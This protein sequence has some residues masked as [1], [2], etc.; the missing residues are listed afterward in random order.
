MVRC[1]FAGGLVLFPQI[2]LAGYSC[3]TWHVSHVSNV[4]MPAYGCP[5]GYCLNPDP[6]CDR[7]DC[8]AEEFSETGKCCVL[9]EGA[10]D[11]C[12]SCDGSG[13]DGEPDCAMVKFGGGL[14]CQVVS[15]GAGYINYPWIANKRCVGAKEGALGCYNQVDL[16]GDNV[17]NDNGGVRLGAC[18]AAPG[19]PRATAS[20]TPTPTE[21]DPMDGGASA[22]VAVPMVASFFAGFVAFCVGLAW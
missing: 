18:C 2:A 1:F 3:G 7:E 20:P 13:V 22:R 21:D 12:V 17:V 15:D 8:T 5:E 16:N 6:Y 10:G 4:D 9:V 11:C 14:D 19:T